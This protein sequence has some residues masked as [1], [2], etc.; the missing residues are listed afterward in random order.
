MENYM[1]NEKDLTQEEKYIEEAIV[2]ARKIQT[3]LWGEANGSWGLEEWRRMF[4]KR[5]KKIE[6]I[7]PSNP[8]AIVELKK[9]L[10]QNAALSIA[11]MNILHFK[12]DID[13]VNND[14]PSNLPEYIDYDFDSPINQSKFPSSVKAR[15]ITEEENDHYMSI[16]AGYVSFMGG[17]P[18]EPTIIGIEPDGFYLCENDEIRNWD[19]MFLMGIQT[20]ESK[21]F[22]NNLNE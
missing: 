10:L 12:D 2:A 4:I 22:M 8:H 9:R 21:D 16:G 17:C 13:I 15:R 14:I 7:D 19:W 20:K 5:V 11:L 6:L 3:F 18:G 1:R